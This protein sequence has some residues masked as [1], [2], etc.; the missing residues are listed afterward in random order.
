MDRDSKKDS[1]T[2]A[3][4]GSKSGLAPCYIISVSYGN[5]SIAL[6]QLAKEQKLDGVHVV[7]CDTGWGHSSWEQRVAEGEEFAKQC[8]FSVHNIHGDETFSDMVRRKKGFPSQ[9]YQFCS[10]TLKGLPFLEWCEEHDPDCEAVIL[11]GKRKDESIA[12]KDTPTHE[13][14]DEYHNGRLIW[15]PLSDYTA[16]DRDEVIAR[17]PFQVLPHRSLECCPCVNANKTDLLMVEN[18]RLEEI[19]ELEIEVGNYMYR[20]Q[21]KM[22]AKGIDEVL[23]WAK[24]PRG[25]FGK[26]PEFTPCVTGMCGM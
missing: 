1:A 24:S 4:Q 15:Y 9:R 21:K 16:K 23:L 18:G 7:Y 19:R 11:I 22:G 5:D 12:R 3:A 26:D 20:A 10:G 2:K 6:I 14:G 13:W 8:G 17:T 25:R